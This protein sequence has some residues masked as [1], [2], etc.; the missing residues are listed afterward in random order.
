MAVK[1][2][3]NAIALVRAT[4]LALICF[5]AHAMSENEREPEVE[6][7]LD[8]LKKDKLQPKE[9]KDP[10]KEIAIPAAVA[11]ACSVYPQLGKNMTA[12]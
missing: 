2:L 11:S 7:A 1:N 8:P 3:G 6:E 5:T 10:E 12:F 4:F 9:D